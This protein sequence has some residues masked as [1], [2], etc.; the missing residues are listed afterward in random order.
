MHQRHLVIALVTLDANVTVERKVSAERFY[1]FHNR[2]A[3]RVCLYQSEQTSTAYFFRLGHL[4]IIFDH[5]LRLTFYFNNN[6]WARRRTKAT[7]VLN[8]VNN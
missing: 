1:I 5:Y 3:L 7:Y 4:K 8:S 6:Q 2:P